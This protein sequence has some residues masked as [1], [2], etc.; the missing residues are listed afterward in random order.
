MRRI[1]C[2]AAVP[3]N[4]QF[5]SRAQTLLNQVC[6][7]RYLQVEVEKRLERLFRRSDCGV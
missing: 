2:A 4:E 3:A 5:V 1:G 7:R 6:G